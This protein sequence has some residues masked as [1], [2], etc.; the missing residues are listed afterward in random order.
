MMS[1]RFIIDRLI[2]FAAYKFGENG[3]VAAFSSAWHAVS[4][5]IE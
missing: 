4:I 3:L 5:G 1:D 2:I